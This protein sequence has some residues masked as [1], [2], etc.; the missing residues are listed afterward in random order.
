MLDGEA[1]EGGYLDEWAAFDDLGGGDVMYYTIDYG[2]G[3]ELEEHI[4]HDATGNY[5]DGG[6]Q[7]FHPYPDNATVTI[8]EQFDYAWALG[9][10]HE[11]V[12]WDKDILNVQPTA[13]LFKQISGN[14]INLQLLEQY[15]PSS[16]DSGAGFRYSF[17]T[18]PDN[19]A[20]SYSAAGTSDTAGFS[21]TPGVTSAWA[22]IYDKDGG[23]SDYNTDMVVPTIN[24]TSVTAAAVHLSWLDVTDGDSQHWR[25]RRSTDGVH[26]DD[27][28]TLPWDAYNFNDTDV[29]PGQ[30]YCPTNGNGKITARR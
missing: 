14:T 11:E 16:V 27:H 21:Y 28:W 1:Y 2:D 29:T 6:V 20:S 22:R 17:S 13:G 15:D 30:T 26:Y 12:V 18:N 8:T 9:E 19:L 24:T 5:F 3:S 7:L 25:V 10:L 23:H 4:G